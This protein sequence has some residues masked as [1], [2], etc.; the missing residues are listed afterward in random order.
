[1]AVQH[2]KL[3]TVEMESFTDESIKVC[4]LQ[5]QKG[6]KIMAEK[7]KLS[8]AD[9]P[10]L[11]ICFRCE[12]VFHKETHLHYHQNICLHNLTNSIYPKKRQMTLQTFQ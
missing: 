8:T 4:L 9:H 1:M 3:S 5:V 6:D 11:W 12:A 10:R 7:C 2:F